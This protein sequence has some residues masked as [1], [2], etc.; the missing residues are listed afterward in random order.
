[1][2]AKVINYCL[3]IYP[4]GLYFLTI[5]YS[6]DQIKEHKKD[7][8]CAMCGENRNAH[9]FLVGIHDERDH[10]QDLGLDGTIILKFI[11]KKWDGCALDTRA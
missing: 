11:F 2:E 8:A 3:E 4:F 6:G 5:Y 9:G 10:M 7:K 1:M